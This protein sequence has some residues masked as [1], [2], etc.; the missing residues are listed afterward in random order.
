MQISEYEQHARE[1]R[2]MAAEMDDPTH[3]KQMEVMAE[4]WE[5]LVRELSK[6]AR[7]AY[8]ATGKIDVQ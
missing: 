6:R 4:I 7:P 5:T 8:E 1:C 2:K 3:K